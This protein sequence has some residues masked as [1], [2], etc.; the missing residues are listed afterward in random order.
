MKPVPTVIFRFSRT[1]NPEFGY[2]TALKYILH[3][4]DMARWMNMLLSG[5]LNEAGE[6]VF[7]SDVIWETWSPV[8]AYLVA[9]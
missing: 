6:E 2:I 1:F 8:N 7:S 3:A 5:G 4:G 9:R